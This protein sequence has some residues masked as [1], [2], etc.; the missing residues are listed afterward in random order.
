VR[1]RENRQTPSVRRERNKRETRR[2]G[3]EADDC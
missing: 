1:R 2:L 3:M